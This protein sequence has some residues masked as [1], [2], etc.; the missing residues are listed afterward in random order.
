MLFGSIQGVSD[1]LFMRE[2]YVIPA[3]SVITRISI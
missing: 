1:A 2:C 3:L